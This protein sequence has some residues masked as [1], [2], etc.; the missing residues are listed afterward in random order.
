MKRVVG[1]ELDWTGLMSRRVL[2]IESVSHWLGEQ[3]SW[4][5]WNLL[6]ESIPWSSL[7]PDRLCERD[8]DLIVAR[9]A[10]ECASAANFFHWL[11][12]NPIGKPTLAIVS[13]DGELI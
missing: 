4:A 11:G 1:A 2:F 10:P 13:A 3:S 12:E 8:V 5:A 6:P 9:A 7:S